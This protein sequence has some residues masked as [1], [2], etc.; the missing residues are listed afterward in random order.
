MCSCETLNAL[1][2]SE[3]LSG[4]AR[5]KLIN[6]QRYLLICNRDREKYFE[7]YR[8]R[9]NRRK[10][11]KAIQ[12]NNVDFLTFVV[13]IFIY[14]LVSVLFASWA[15]FME[16]YHMLLIE[17][18]VAIVMV[19]G[20]M[21]CCFNCRGK[22]G[23]NELDEVTCKKKNGRNELDEVTCKKKNDSTSSC[24]INVQKDE[25]ECGESMRLLKE[26]QT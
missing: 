9:R 3:Q 17:I 22:Q 6:D 16:W 7:G 11:I 8:K 4:K 18:A 23:R 2:E 25:E 24:C 26:V 13:V 20:V 19:V 10:C 5:M 12:K 14:S 21:I 15:N 1:L